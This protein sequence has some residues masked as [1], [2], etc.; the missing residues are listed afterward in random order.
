V[1]QYAHLHVHSE[2]S[3]LDG[4]ARIGD[5]MAEVTRLGMTAVAISDHG[6]MHGAYDFYKQAI[7]AG[8]TPVIGIEAYV[9]PASRLAKKRVTWGRPDQRGDDVSGNGA[10]THATMWARNNEGL[11]NLFRLTTEASMTGQYQKPRMDAELI[12]AH[13]AGIMATTGCPSGE[14]QTRLRLDQPDGAYAA[15]AKYQDIFGRDNYFLELMDHGLDIEK[16]VREGL[17]DIGR[18]LGIPPVVTNDSHYVHASQA[19][20]HDALLCVQTG[21]RLDDPDRFR[22]TGDGYYLKSA[23]EMYGIATDELWQ[24]GCANTV[25]IAERVDTA[26]M[27]EHRNLMPRFPVPDGETEASLLSR[28]TYDGLRDRYPNGVPEDRMTRATYELDIING[29][30]YGGYFL[31]VADLM[32]WAREQGIR[33]GVRGSAVG[34]LVGYAIGISTIDPMEHGLLFER[35]LNPERPSMPDVDMDFDERRRGEVIAYA[36]RQYGADRVAQI[37]TMGRIKA[38]AAVKDAAR[39]L[40]FPFGVGD[41]I[42]KTMPPDVMGKGVTLSEM[43]DPSHSRFAES[44]EFR[45]LCAADQSAAK[46]VEVA[47]GMEGLIRQTGVHA[48]GVIM[49][50]E[51]LVDHIPLTRRDTDGAIITQF[52]YEQCDALGLVKMDFLGLS[53]LTIIDDALRNIKANRGVDVDL[54]TIAMDDPKTFALLASGNTKGLFQV[55]SAGIS[56]LL[57]MIQ[58]TEFAHIPAVLALYRP[59]PMGANSHTNYALRKNGQQEIAP[60]HPELAEPL[61]GILGE[62]YGLIVYQEQVME[63]AVELAGYSLGKADLLRKA[64]GKKV[65]AV[66]DKEFVPFSEGM[67]GRGY[68]DEAIQTLWDILV[69]FADYAFGRGHTTSYGYITYWTAYLKANYPAEYLAALL[70]GNADDKAKTAT[71]LAECRRAG[72][73]VLPPDVN[74]SEHAYTA[75]GGNI[76]F[77]LG[78]VRNVGANVV[79]AIVRCRADAPYKDFNDFLAKVDAVACSKRA[80]ESLIKAGAFDSL[81]HPRRGLMDIHAEA[82]EQHADRKRNESHGQ[83][84]LFGGIL[85]EPESGLAMSAAIPDAEW[86]R[87]TLLALEREMLGLYVSGHPLDEAERTLRANRD[88]AV[89]DVL[90]EHMSDRKPVVLAGLVT[91]VTRKVSKKGG[92]WAIAALEDL[93]GSVEVLFFP[94]KY[95]L[96]ADL[97]TPDRVVKVTGNVSRRDGSVSVYGDT[98][99]PLEVPVGGAPP[100]VLAAPLG[101]VNEASVDGLRRVLTAHPGDA[102]VH[103]RLARPAGGNLLLALNNARVADGPSFRSEVKVLLGPGGIS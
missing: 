53:N 31:V 76:R 10:Y 3:M 89:A 42:T 41:K 27:F 45:A 5:M 52:E 86:D 21:S 90:D 6:N 85:D 84:D 39:I 59:G 22:F 88:H 51:P 74:S 44:A 87:K 16:R 7:A 71:F 70:T 17:A 93:T 4:A 15:A 67:R 33:C 2:Y 34:S 35:L 29:K 60:I 26:G 92:L 28:M 54:D 19:Q 94:Q 66:L 49:A 81:G 58:P 11:H 47:K 36:A 50:S 99:T 80:V 95:E 43:A 30:D 32:R 62:T 78:A 12:A 75:V 40:G 55:E 77:G 65:K 24:E 97:L 61:K 57:R 56:A 23:A 73:R 100:V 82:V 96:V 64:M 79:D 13:S 83:F 9:A 20:A 103:M 102:P 48:A 38:K 68:S 25:R 46:V 18:R 63:I 101:W 8:I 91:A 14:V 1:N 98:A 69:P 37:V 72:I